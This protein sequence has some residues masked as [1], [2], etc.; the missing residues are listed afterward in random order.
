MNVYQPA[1]KPTNALGADL[2]HIGYKFP[3]QNNGMMWDSDWQHAAL[4]TPGATGGTNPLITNYMNQQTTENQRSRAANTGRW[5]AASSYLK[6]FATPFSPDII[7]KMKGQN[8]MASLG[9]AHNAF[10]QQ[11]GLMDA[12]GQ[13]DASSQSAAMAEANRHAMGATVGANNQLGIEAQKANNAAGMSVGSSIL[14]AL[15]QDVP[16][17]YSGFASLGLMDQ[18]QQYN[19]GLTENMMNRPISPGMTAGQ[20]PIGGRYDNNSGGNAGFN[21][22]N[23]PAPPTPQNKGG[24][25]M[26]DPND[27]LGGKFRGGF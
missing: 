21:W 7:Q 18:N 26:D 27:W 8:S 25:R 2:T 9:A 23:P 24:Q 1:N 19:R 3:G 5:D 14:N 6:Q 20:R 4:G 11:Q 17:D 16:Q 10:N 15:P 12:S 13:G 22:M